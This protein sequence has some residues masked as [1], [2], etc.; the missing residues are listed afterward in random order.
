MAASQD[1]AATPRVGRLVLRM[2]GVIN[3]HAG[4]DPKK[5]ALSAIAEA[6][7]PE[8]DVQ[9]FFRARVG[10]RQLDSSRAL[11]HRNLRRGA[12][13]STSKQWEDTL[14]FDIPEQASHL[15]LRLYRAEVA[16][17][18][19]VQVTA[20]RVRTPFQ[21]SGP[22]Q[23]A[24]VKRS[25]HCFISRVQRSL[26]NTVVATA[27]SFS[28]ARL[29]NFSFSRRGL[30][31]DKENM[32]QQPVQTDVDTSLRDRT[33]LRETLI[34]GARISLAALVAS[35]GQP[36]SFRLYGEDMQPNGIVEVAAA[37]VS[38]VREGWLQRRARSSLA[39]R[40][41]KVYWC[42]LLS[43][44]QIIFYSSA[45]KQPAE[46]RGQIHLASAHH[47]ALSSAHASEPNARSYI[48]V[49]CTS[50]RGLCTDYLKANHP[51]DAR[52]WLQDFQEIFGLRRPQP[53][54]SVWKAGA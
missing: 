22:L 20:A 13:V 47:V 26:S 37:F 19:P 7:P 49:I 23:S 30:P 24:A 50:A 12:G 3:V 35:D 33:A 51:D 39:R 14:S 29:Q 45:A 48:E 2:L 53:R 31:H 1:D 54:G 43:D 52:S 10:E 42:E 17:T 34:G 6:G 40:K 5:P 25:H 9:L 4:Q 15:E 46:M 32:P 16:S 8:P 18:M 28:K 36:R 27:A 38:M 44:G 21:T 11:T 41:W